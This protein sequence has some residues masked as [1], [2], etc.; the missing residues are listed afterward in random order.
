MGFIKIAALPNGDTLMEFKLKT[1]IYDKEDDNEF[2]K[3]IT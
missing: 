2:I 1:G 3:V